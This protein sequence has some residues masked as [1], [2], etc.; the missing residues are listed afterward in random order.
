[1]RMPPIRARW[2]LLVCALILGGALS[3]AAR[4]EAVLHVDDDAAPGGDGSSWSTAYRFLQDALAA[5]AGNVTEIR[6]A[7][8]TYVPDR[9]H[10]SPSGT[11]D[12]AATFQLLSGVAILGGFAGVGSPDPDARDI[13]Q[14]ATVL[15]GDLIGDDGPPG[16]FVNNAENSR[17]IVTA[18]STDLS[19]VLDGF[20]LTGG[21][22]DGPQ[23]LENLHLARGAG[24]WN[25]SGSPAIRNCRLEYN[26]AL[27][28]GGGM[29][30]LTG[31][32]AEVTGCTFTGN[33]APGLGY[34]GGL[35]NYEC[36]T[37]VTDCEFVD[38]SADTG[39][40]MQS[41]AGDTVVSG[42]VFTGNT[43]VYGGG[44]A[45]TYGATAAVTD[46]TF[47]GNLAGVGGGLY[48]VGGTT[49][50][51]GSV[52][53]DNAPNHVAGNWNDAG[54]NAFC[55]LCDDSSGPVLEVP[56][57]YPTIQ[58]AINAACDGSEIVVAPGTYF[59]RINF[60]GKIITVR[61]SDG[62]DVTTIDGQGKGSV[63]FFVNEETPDSV[64]EGFTITHGSAEYGG[65]AQIQEATPTITD[66][67]FASNLAT[68]G[69][70]IHD[71]S[72]E[73]GG[74]NLLRCSF[75]GN[76]ALLAAGA[77]FSAGGLTAVDCV[78][79]DNDG[80]E[81]PGAVGAL[82]LS[83]SFVNC[84]FTGNSADFVGGGVAGGSNTMLMANCVF[85]RN[86]ASIGGGLE[87]ASYAGVIANCTFSLNQGHGIG[88]IDNTVLSNC[89]LWGN[90]PGQI[91]DPSAV[92][93][94]SDVQGGWPGPGNLDAD[95]LFVQPGT[96]D[97][98]LSF[99]S[100][101]VNAGNN[102]DLPPDTFDLDGDGNTTEPIPLDLGGS[103]RV[104]GSTVDMG[105]YEGEFDQQEAAASESDLDGGDFVILV[106]SCG[107]L[108]PL[109]SAAAF[110]VNTSGP[111]DA[112]FVVTEYDADLYPGAGG[113]SELSVI[114]GTETSL[115]DGEYLATLFIPFNAVSLG[116]ID[117]V[118]VN[119]TRYDPDA[120]NWALA[121][122]GNSANSPGHDTPVGDRVVVVG[123]GAWGVTGELGDY[124]VYWDPAIQQGFAWAKVDV[125][126]DFGLGVAL[127]PAD[128]R[129][130]PDGAVGVTDFL[131]MLARW[132]DA[133]VGS[134]CDIDFNGVIGVADFIALVDAW[135]PCPQAA[136]T[137][138]LGRRRPALRPADLDRNGLVDAG[139]L[140][141]LK[142]AWGPCRDCPADLDGD[143][144]V[145]TRDML[146][147][148]R[149]WGAPRS[150]ASP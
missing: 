5:A 97:V 112:T 52:F 93:E 19:A 138:P 14:F 110:I 134:P 59:E 39:G 6:V 47:T 122:S 131:A 100:P 71:I 149:D 91:E 147:L 132:G 133:S 120:G 99:G 25:A 81:G 23:D 31:T 12:R 126:A 27:Q 121:V 101:C 105:A 129:Q 8:G 33:V 56:A 146:S 136:R 73:G 70:A 42:C 119:L 3:P 48:I 26:Y 15:S 24:I 32:A 44:L 107:P 38:N 95:P 72:Y 53:C 7:Q 116:A 75:D 63:V 45:N 78:F 69:G 111:D 66:C 125:A 142:S 54:G 57:G 144:R 148:L 102:S 16:S 89:I 143:G 140:E 30:N 85:S 17:N 1:M 29:Y 104:Q 41:T 22:A 2:I 137:S 20:T 103:A 118:G 150:S 84:V 87:D 135:G 145:D 114:L 109:E 13:D 127:C 18:S 113:Y 117:P 67:I 34:G 130:T 98:R 108:D 79:T 86:S 37:T 124:G 35:R 82:D 74:L 61:S 115:A 49:T 4:A 28:N 11:G 50:L 64:L 10:A 77:I 76:Q 141:T 94:Y 65:A 68:I 90:A 62:P 123:G 139:D 96:D 58:S 88:S 55:P 9:S 80:A 60:S 40:G 83:A 128:C 43:A 106:P 51:S 21:N 36:F 92:V 46:C